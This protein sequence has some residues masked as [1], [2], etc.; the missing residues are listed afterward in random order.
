MSNR[1]I[2]IA[3]ILL[4]I[5]IIIGIGIGIKIGIVSAHE[6][7]PAEHV[8]AKLHAHPV[9]DLHGQAVLGRVVLHHEHLKTRVAHDDQAMHFSV[10]HLQNV[11]AA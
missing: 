7:T 5:S 8:N 6:L 11:N 1:Q 3:R 4:I 9:F 2:S 10:H